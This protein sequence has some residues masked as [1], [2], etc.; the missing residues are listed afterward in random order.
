MRFPFDLSGIKTVDFFG[1]TMTFIIFGSA[2]LFSLNL[3]SIIP[4]KYII[5]NFQFFVFSYI[6][7]LSLYAFSV[8]CFRVYYNYFQKKEDKDKSAPTEEE[9]KEK[10][11]I[12]KEA[13]KIND[14]DLIIY[15]NRKEHSLVEDTHK[16]LNLFSINV[17]LLFSIFVVIG[18]VIL[19]SFFKSSFVFAIAYIFVIYCLF[20]LGVSADND[21]RDFSGQI[22]TNIAKERIKN[23]SQ[24]K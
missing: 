3:L 13:K 11:E 5:F 22:K 21:E 10:E 6:I 8:I 4:D 16:H 2:L 19:Y 12:E 20:R 7:G 24:I 9:K 23:K 15:R 14:I 1:Y 17:R 18:F